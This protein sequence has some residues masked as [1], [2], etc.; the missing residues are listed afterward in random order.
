MLWEFIGRF[1]IL[2]WLC[3]LLEVYVLFMF[4]DVGKFI[5]ILDMFVGFI[6][7]NGNE[8]L[9]MFF[10]VDSMEFNEMLFLL[11]EVVFS[12]IFFRLL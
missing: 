5:F 3:V 2:F 11:D 7:L 4:M 6:F 9:V 1:L 12:D 10:G 8:F